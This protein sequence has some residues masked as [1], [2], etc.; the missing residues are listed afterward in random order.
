MTCLADNI[1]SLD[2]L[3][4]KS[5]PWKGNFYQLISLW[6]IMDYL[7]AYADQIANFLSVLV[8]YE[9]KYKFD[10]SK[11][12]ISDFDNEILEGWFKSI[13]RQSKELGLNISVKQIYAAQRVLRSN[14]AHNLPIALEKVRETMLYE[15]QSVMFLHIRPESEEYYEE[16]HLFEEELFGQK[17]NDNFG[18]AIRDIKEAGKC[19]ALRRYTACVF[20]LMRVVEI[21]L[22]ALAKDR[23]V[24]F[25]KTKNAPLELREL[26]EM[27]EG[28]ENAEKQI[29]GYPKTAAREA[30]FAFYH[31]A[32]NDLRAF[33][34]LYRSRTMHA[35]EFYDREQAYKAM[36]RVAS[37]MKTLSD[38]I[39]E[40]KRTPLIWKKP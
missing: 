40:T 29:Q 38:R 20:H 13:K 14:D 19:F 6:E 17:V 5:P 4:K 7:Q 27:F 37:F 24:T 28:L 36:I 2:N 22:R 3:D 9:Y 32:M 35:R 15:L 39:S 11:E 12:L 21:G 33:K 1:L 26:K 16:K 8:S 10:L 25:T 34:N 30:Q 23:R 31:S 18:S